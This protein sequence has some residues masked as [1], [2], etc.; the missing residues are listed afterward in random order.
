MNAWIASP[1]HDHGESKSRPQPAWAQKVRID[2]IYG[3]NVMLPEC[4]VTFIPPT[5]WER[6][7]G[8]LKGAFAE[9]RFWLV[10]SIL[11]AGSVTAFA[12]GFGLIR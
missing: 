11:L 3:F 7:S 2:V 12:W 9:I 5:R 10:Q 6:I 4:A 1:H 8:A